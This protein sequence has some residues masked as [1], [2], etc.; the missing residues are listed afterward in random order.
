AYKEYYLK[1]TFKL[2]EETS[3]AEKDY[4]IA[5]DQF[6]VPFESQSLLYLKKNTIA[7][8][9][10][11]ELE[12]SIKVS[13][14][15]LKVEFSTKSGR[16]KT[17][18]YEGR[19]FIVKPLTPNFWRAPIDNDLGLIAMAP[20]FLVPFLKRNLYKWKRANRQQKLVKM[21]VDQI[22]PVAVRVKTKSRM[23]FGLS[24]M[25]ITYTIYGN[26]D[27]QIDFRFYP[28]ANMIRLGMQIAI[29]ADFEN[30]S[31]YGKGPHETQ[32]D[33]KLG[34]AVGVYSLKVNEMTHN[35]VKPQENGNRTDVRWITLRNDTGLGLLIESYSDSLL[36][37]ST[38]PY[39]MSD[40]ENAKHIN[41]LP[42]RDFIT[43]NIDYKQ[44]GVGGDW[45]A[46]A[47]THSEFK[48]KKN[49]R[50]FYSYRIR[51]F[52]EDSDNVRQLLEYRLP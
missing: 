1:C 10:Y 32:F 23:P 38:W 27:I 15:K 26:G 50:Y 11:E 20:K 42:K 5:F 14:S 19:E 13:N 48:L 3:W 17:F 9:N 51:P 8:V 47:R 12:D 52:N 37:I 36:N 30:I 35:Y 39:S 40:L 33:R 46:I 24:S 43:V 22:S 49:R 21:T 25:A 28:K 7:E 6:K 16:I 34:A 44:R 18:I 31:W 45:P 4:V 29:P 2:K 41:D